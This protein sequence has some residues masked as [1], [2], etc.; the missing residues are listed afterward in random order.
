MICEAL[1]N[2][3]DIPQW[4]REAL[5]SLPEIMASSD[6]LAGRLERAALDTVEAALVANHIGQEFDAVVISGSK[7]SNG[8]SSKNGNGSSNGNG[9]FGVI[10]IADPAVTARCDGEMESGTT[11]RV[12]LLKADIASRE[13]RFE[14][15]P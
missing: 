9:P 10:Q 8:S 12:R 3:H 11:V 5:P 15:L 14:L 1:S 4:A 6:Q 7:P 2:N 13:I